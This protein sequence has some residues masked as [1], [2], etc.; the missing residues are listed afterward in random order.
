MRLP[1]EGTPPRRRSRLLGSLFGI[2]LGLVVVEGLLRVL[3]LP[4]PDRTTPDFFGGEIA[5]HTTFAA[6]P[7]LFYRLSPNAG[8]WNPNA[9][10]LRGPLPLPEK[11]PSEFRIAC[12]GDSVTAGLFVEYHQAFGSVL[13][14]GLQQR[15]A[16]GP[17]TLILAGLPGYSSFQSRR[18]FDKD[19]ARLAPDLV[20]LHCGTWNDFLPAITRPDHELAGE[21]NS[22]LQSL[23]MVRLLSRVLGMTSSKRLSHEEFAQNFLAGSAPNG[24]RVPPDRFRQNME[25]MIRGAQAIA[26]QVVVVVPARSGKVALGLQAATE[27][28]EIVREI[29]QRQ[30]VTL[31]DAERLLAAYEATLPA[32]PAS[33]PNGT[34]PCF[35]DGV[36]LREAGHKLLAGEILRVLLEHPPARFAAGL[37]RK[38]VPPP[39]LEMLGLDRKEIDCWYPTELRIQGRGF[40]GLQPSDR[41]FLGDVWM[42]SWQALDDGHL[43]VRTPPTLR[44]GHAWLEVVTK[45]GPVRGPE[46]LVLPCRLEAKPVAGRPGVLDLELQCQP[47]ADVEVFGSGELLAAPAMT[48]LG[49]WNLAGLRARGSE[50]HD[51]LLFRPLSLELPAVVG[52][53]DA[54]GIWRGQLE[55]LG[56][57]ERVH[58]QGVG[59]LD[60]SRNVGMAT[61]CSTLAIPR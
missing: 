11:A 16:A 10:G 58:V 3:G 23:C 34:G 20:V 49:P 40:L 8:H 32:E 21:P 52:K 46:L 51:D 9:L 61:R 4:K 41:V 47:L 25:A 37:E 2:A 36:H 54:N 42:P 26:A 6:D 39:A 17:V 14:R 35:F 59:W 48:Q 13:A 56:V 18:L 38:S 60:R 31:V 22:G 30:G 57:G 5:D 24:R 53:T 27:Y 15:L 33:A 45:F 1:H 55:L 19:V 29:G 12:V 44:P 43:L 28:R 50:H 7:D